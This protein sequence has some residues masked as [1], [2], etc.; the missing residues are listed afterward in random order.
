MPM[1][2]TDKRLVNGLMWLAAILL[3]AYFM[4]WYGYQE[5]RTQEEASRNTLDGVNKNEAFLKFYPQMHPANL[6]TNDAEPASE[7]EGTPLSVRKAEYLKDT[8]L[9]DKQIEEAKKASRMDFPDWAKVPEDKKLHAG[10]YFDRT[11][12]ELKQKL[13]DKT[14]RDAGVDCVDNKIG[15]EDYVG[16]TQMD[17]EKAEEFLRK[18]FIAQKVIDLSVKAK[19]DEEQFERGKNRKPEAFMRIIKISPQPSVAAPPTALVPNPQYKPEEHLKNPTSMKGSPYI[20]RSWRPFIQEYPVEMTL[21]CDINTFMRFL[22]FVREPKQF[23]VIRNLEIVSPYLRESIRSKAELKYQG[24]AGLS[25]GSTTATGASRIL[26]LKD[27]QIQVKM[28]AEGM[29]F[30]DPADKPKGLYSKQEKVKTDNNKRK[31]QVPT[32]PPPGGGTG[33]QNNQTDF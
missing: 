5:A 17:V 3:A 29:D 20:I 18:L 24:E 11:Y 28:T 31:I 7:P 15:F 12:H 13:L 8:G 10:G 1:D 2:E 21:Q 9:Q 33:N 32:A 30:F 16:D 27:N 4:P 25:P 23:L 26:K 19:T 6:G 22:S 14:L